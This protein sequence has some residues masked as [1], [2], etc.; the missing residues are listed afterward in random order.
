MAS[1]EKVTIVFRHPLFIVAT[2]DK[3]CNEI[4]NYS[5]LGDMFKV[6]ALLVI[7]YGMRGKGSGK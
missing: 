3:K 1:V 4:T 7:F 2:L 6:V 5:R